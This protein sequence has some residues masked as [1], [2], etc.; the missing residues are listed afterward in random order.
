LQDIIAILGMDELAEDDKVL[1]RRAKK[2]AKILKPSPCL[3]QN[4][5]T[6][7]TGRYVKREQA[8][9]DFEKILNGE[10]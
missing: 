7:M 8:I 6:G 2:S 9:A 3:Q 5:S 4:F 1:V 10:V